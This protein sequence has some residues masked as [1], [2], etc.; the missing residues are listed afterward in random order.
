MPETDSF[1]HLEELKETNPV[2]LAMQTV[3][4]VMRGGLGKHNADAW[5]KEPLQNHTLKAARHAVSAQLISEGLSPQ[6]NEDHLANA[7]CR[8]TMAYAL[9]KDLPGKTS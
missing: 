8:S 4:T 3:R 1:D 5:R 9:I 7:I 2:E 6:D